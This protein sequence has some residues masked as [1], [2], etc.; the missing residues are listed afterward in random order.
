MAS[1]DHSN[2]PPISLN[3]LL[4]FSFYSWPAAPTIGEHFEVDIAQYNPIGK[5]VAGM[6]M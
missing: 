2:D 6:T 4:L 5:I 1:S 3:L